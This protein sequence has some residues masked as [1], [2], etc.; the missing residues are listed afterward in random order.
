[1]P[2][3]K[4]QAAALNFHLTV[5]EKIDISEALGSEDNQSSFTR[6]KALK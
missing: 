2:T 1:V 6:F 5:K 4:N 3:K